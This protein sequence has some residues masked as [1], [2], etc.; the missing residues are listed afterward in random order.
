VLNIQDWKST[1]GGRPFTQLTTPY[2][3]NHDLWIDPRHPQR[4]IEGNEGGACV[5]YNGGASW[6]TIYNQPTAQFYHVTADGR[7]FWILDDLTPLQPL[8][9]PVLDKP[10][11]L[12]TPRPS[13]RVPPPMGFG[14]QPGPGKN[15]M[16]ALGVPATYYETTTPQG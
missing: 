12:F 13:P 1:D 6:S 4:M 15:Y 3:D 11:H 16:L 5:S 7:S 8:A 10:A 9:E 14:R 2:G